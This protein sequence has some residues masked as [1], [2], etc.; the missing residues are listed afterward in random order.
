MIS[1]RDFLNIR[2]WIIKIHLI[3]QQTFYTP[4]ILLI[5][6]WNRIEIK[7]IVLLLYYSQHFLRKV[8]EILSLEVAE[9]TASLASKAISR[10]HQDLRRK[11]GERQMWGQGHQ[12]KP[13]TPWVPTWACGPRDGALRWNAP[14]EEP[15]GECHSAHCVS[16]TQLPALPSCSKHA[17]TQVLGACATPLSAWGSPAE[18]GD[19]LSCVWKPKDLQ[20][21]F[22]SGYVQCQQFCHCN[23]KIASWLALSN[24]HG[25]RS[26]AEVQVH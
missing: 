18:R 6:S 7:H 8:L 10:G 5:C 12:E 4:A 20:R 21:D 26:Q 15:A 11:E 3:S 19:V 2:P 23:G 14:A 24:R 25:I 1:W 17:G 13:R 16:G 22:F 9:A